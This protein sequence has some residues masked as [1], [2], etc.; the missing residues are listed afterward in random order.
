M[1][2]TGIQTARFAWT[3]EAWGL[4]HTELELNDINLLRARPTKGEVRATWVVM[5]LLSLGFL[6]T[7]PFAARAWP[8]SNLLYACAGIAAFAEI[9]TGMLLL[10]QAS[11]LRDYA[12]LALGVGY[13]LGGLVI[14]VNLLCVADVS[15]RLW[16]FRL[17]HGV[18]VLGVLLYALL[19]RHTLLPRKRFRALA[20][21]VIGAIVPFIVLL[22]AYLLYRPFPLPDIIHGSNYVTVADLSV[23]GAQLVVVAAAWLILVTTPRKTV[24][25]VWMSVVATAVAIDIVLFVLGGTLLSVGLYISKL[26]NLWP[27]R[28]FSR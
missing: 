27:P 12:G 25:S 21:Y 15:T 6:F 23:N 20:R 26:N 24:L 5:G 28:L 7:V 14:A 10:T 18:F 9:I 13:L 2:I 3:E 1:A 4:L 22:V 17:W 11:L 8:P 19:Q 16:L